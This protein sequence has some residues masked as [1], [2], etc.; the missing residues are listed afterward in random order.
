MFAK[1][2]KRF[3]IEEVAQTRE[4]RF[5]IPHT[6]IKRNGM[7]T[8]DA[9][10]VTRTEDGRWNLTAEEVTIDAESL[11]FD[12]ND[13][14]AHF[15]EQLSWTE[16]SDAPAMPNKMRQL[17]ND[18]EDL[19]VVMV[20]PWADDVS[21]NK[22]K[23]YN[24]HMNVYAQNGCLPVQL[25]QQEYHMHY[26]S[27]SLHASS[28]E[29]FAALRDHIKATEKDPVRAYNA[30]T[31]RPCRII[32]RAPGL[33]ADNPQQSEEASHMGS[34][35]NYPCRKC[36]WGG[37]QK[38]KETGQI[39]HDCHLA[40][41][42]RNATEI[43][44]EL[45]K[46]LQLATKG[47]IDA[48]KKRQ[49]NSGTKDK[50]AQY[51]IDKLVS[52]CEAIKTAD[53]RRNIEDISR[54]LQSWLN[55][56]PGD[57]M[58][59]LLDLT[60]LDPSQDTPVELLHTVLLGVIKY[61]WHSMN[62]VQWKDEDRHLLAIRL[63]STDLSGLTVPPIRAS[64]MIQYKNNLIGKHFKTL[65]QT[66]AFHVDGIAS[67]EQLTLIVAAGNL[68]ARLWVPAI[69]NMEAYLEDLNVAIANLLDAFDVVDPL[70]IIIKIKLHLLS[71]IG[72]DI[73]RFGPAIRFSTEIFEAF[74]SVFRMCSVNSNHIAPSRDISR[75][76]ASMDR[77]KHLLSGGFWW[78]AE[79]SSW[80]QAGAAVRRVVEDDPVFQRHLG[81]VS[82][83]PVAPG[84]IRLTS[85]KKQPP[86][87][88]H[89]TKA[90]K[91]WDFGAHPEPDSLWRMGQYVTT[92]SG[93]RVPKNGWVFAKDRTG[94]SIFGRVDEILVGDGAVI[95]LEQFLCAELR[96][97][98]YDWPVARRP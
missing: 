3:W 39:Y 87:H 34:N 35:A 38:Q 21:G 2:Y 74:N 98:D 92:I 71:H 94:K 82:S 47:N 41:I 86:I 45:Q 77:L 30:T 31:Q 60:G 73:R 95:T 58:N 65:M 89:T 70:R 7:L 32:L 24:K 66:L 68:G 88:W 59:P 62:T 14:T 51:W 1:G 85:S 18:N 80:S 50:V 36:H 8:T 63:Q 76:F 11:E 25:L 78:N 44:E 6:W 54:E 13:I 53:P 15:G 19:F 52:R 40:G 48:V 72:V 57:K 75:K 90:S 28:A 27:T 84:F 49:T 55:E 5:V 37:T 23:Q 69:D 67:P 79:T 33:P 10:I 17:V 61:I 46:Q 93:D 22:S 16:G 91:H 12:F 96:H 4:G 64:Y 9:Q 42:A 83:K 97:P 56:Q 29:Q 81:W 43:W 20:S 26:V